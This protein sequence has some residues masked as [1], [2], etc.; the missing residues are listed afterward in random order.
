MKTL[1]IFPEE[2]TYIIN[3]KGLIPKP[4]KYTKLRLHH[5]YFFPEFKGVVKVDEILNVNNAEYYMIRYSSNMVACIP[6]LDRKHLDGRYELVKDTNQLAEENIIN[7][8]TP[9]YGYEIKFWFVKNQIDFH[10]IKYKEFYKYFTDK[11]FMI[12]DGKRYI[13][14]CERYKGRRE[15][16]MHLIKY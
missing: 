6:S 4:L 12:E 5:K 8:N 9:Y 2:I 13:L 11:E 15:C 14:T 16:Q 7:S 3:K 1:N 10:K